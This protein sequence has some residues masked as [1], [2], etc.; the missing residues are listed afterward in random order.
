MLRK[1]VVLIVISLFSFVSISHAGSIFDLF[2][3]GPTA[4]T[5]YDVDYV[6]GERQAQDEVLLI[7]IKGIIQEI[8]EA[9]SMPFEFKRNM[10]D[11][12]RKDLETALKRSQVKGI[13]LEIDSP[14]GEATASDIIHHN[15][16]KLKKADKPLVSL[17]GS[18]GAS[19]A[20]YVACASKKIYAHPTSILGSIGVL[21]QSP[22]LEKLAEI[23]GYRQVTIKSKHTPKKDVLS[24]FREM[25][26]EENEMLMLLVESIY[27]RFL[28]VVMEGRGKTREEALAVSDG[29]ILSAE[30]AKEK[31]LIDGIGYREDALEEIKRLAGLKEY[32]LVKR[33]VKKGFQEILQ[34]LAMMNS[35]GPALIEYF[36][37]M[38]AANGVPAVMFQ[39]KMPAAGQ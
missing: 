16:L 31:G 38:V 29:G 20:Y 13:L 25:T 22:N 19:G 36:N 15:L 37:R 8:D 11:T 10:M 7:Q 33:R 35:G 14:G 28:A 26:A 34:D 23:I 32:K 21:L 4:E 30:Q 24:P 12:L 27:E 39:L 2:I 3:P 6:E 17:I 18:M 5:R 9:E 1:T